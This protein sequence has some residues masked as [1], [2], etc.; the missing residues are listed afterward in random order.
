MPS[1]SPNLALK[2]SASFPNSEFFGVKLVNGHPTKC[3]L[4]IENGEADALQLQFIGGSLLTP[5]GVPGAPSPPSPVRNLTA[6]KYNL[7]IPAGQ[8]ETVTYTFVTEMHPQDL[9]LNLAAVIKDKAGVV[10]STNFYNETISIAEAPTSIFDP[11][12]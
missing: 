11:Q 8:S 1:Q 10:Y 2:L 3:V 12:M 6:Q 5:T 9:T 7:N 4:S